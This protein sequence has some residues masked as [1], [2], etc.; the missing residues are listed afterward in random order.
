MI[1]QAGAVENEQLNFNFFGLSSLYQLL[2][3]CFRLFDEAS[4]Y[5][6]FCKCVG[7]SQWI[8]S[9]RCDVN[10]ICKLRSWMKAC[11][12]HQH[13]AGGLCIYDTFCSTGQVS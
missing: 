8:C 9:A 2:V 3:D 13:S 5:S 7:D 11:R 4:H 10:S 12:K 6:T 1:K